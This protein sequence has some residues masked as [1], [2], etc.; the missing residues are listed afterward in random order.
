VMILTKGKGF[1]FGGHADGRS[2]SGSSAEADATDTEEHEGTNAEELDETINGEVAPIL[3]GLAMQT[4]P[5]APDALARYA[6]LLHALSR[7]GDGVPVIELPA[8]VAA[9]GVHGDEW[10]GKVLLTMRLKDMRV[11][12]AQ[13]RQVTPLL[14]GRPDLVNILAEGFLT[15]HRD[16][17]DRFVADLPTAA[18]SQY[19]AFGLKTGIWHHGLLVLEPSGQEPWRIVFTTHAMA[20][21]A[22]LD[23]QMQRVAAEGA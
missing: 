4:K 20:I 11:T 22:V 18:A 7:P 1:T 23:D 17:L 16:R 2:P 21:S 6:K 8:P 3:G 19:E 10:N 14:R 9:N 5:P 15:A 13:L 12:V